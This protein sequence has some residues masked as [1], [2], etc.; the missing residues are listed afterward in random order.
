MPSPQLDAGDHSL[1]THVVFILVGL[2]F[3]IPGLIIVIR[4]D[5]LPK[6]QRNAWQL[7]LG[8]I[9]MVVGVVIGCGLAYTMYTKEG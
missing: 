1:M 7:A 2:A 6:A 4:Q 3:F 8:F 9:L 5:K